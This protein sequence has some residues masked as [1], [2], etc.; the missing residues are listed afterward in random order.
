MLEIAD[1]RK[2]TAAAQC[3]DAALAWLQHICMPDPMFPSGVIHTLY[4]DTPSLHSYEEKRAGDFIKTKV[5]LRWYDMVG[6]TDDTR[7]TAY[8]EVKRRIGSSRQ[9]WRKPLALD[10]E[11]LATAS[12]ADQGFRDVLTEA[13]EVLADAFPL[14]PVPAVVLSYTRYRFVCPETLARVCLDTGIGT[15]RINN[16]A[17]PAHGRAQLPEIVMEIK[18]KRRDIPRWF[19]Q[20]YRWGFRQRSFSK[21]G[22]CVARLMEER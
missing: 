13:D 12:L 6:D 14:P 4:Y 21:Y 22:E 3:A 17:L 9:K 7:Y 11:W 2:F 8:L 20:P 19:E 1:E 15:E 5:R 16:G 18:N 10:R